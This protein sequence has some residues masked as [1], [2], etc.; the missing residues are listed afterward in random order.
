[1]FSKFHSSV[2]TSLV[3]LG[4]G[5]ISFQLQSI[6]Q[7]YG[8]IEQPIK[9]W[10]VVLNPWNKNDNLRTMKRVMNRFGYQEVNGNQTEWDILRMVEFTFDKTKLNLSQ[11]KA[12]QKVNHI[13]A[14]TFLTNKLHLTTTTQSKYIP[15]AFQFPK[16]INE[17]K[18]FIEI[19]P[20]IKFVEKNYDNRGV[21][22]VDKKE[23]NFDMKSKY[24][25]QFIENPLLIDERVFDFG[26]YVLISSVD[27]LRIYR[28]KQEVLPRFCPEPYYP[29]DPNNVEKYVIYE[30]HIPVWKMPSLQHYINNLGFSFKT[31]IETH[32]TNQG[33]NITNMWEQIDDAI[34]SLIMSKEKYFINNVS[35]FNN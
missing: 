32:L 19:N 5:L 15:P 28:Y 3:V 31:S 23:I 1:M 29:F 11:L 27:P 7:Q 16:M 33:Y 34:V 26:V 17:F 20:D 22:I 9:Y 12:H 10:A 4:I 2:L 13:P 6:Y 21:K 30:T 35:D 18:K 14:M 25:Q 8:K 24:V